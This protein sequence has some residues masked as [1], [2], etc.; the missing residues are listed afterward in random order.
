[1]AKRPDD[2]LRRVQLADPVADKVVR[3]AQLAVE[4]VSDRLVSLERQAIVRGGLMLDGPWP[5]HTAVRKVV[6]L[7]PGAVNK[8][9]HGL[10]RALRGWWI[11]DLVAVGTTTGAG[12]VERVKT[13]GAGG[14]PKDI[15][16][17]WLKPIGYTGA[18]ALEVT[19]WAF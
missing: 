16:D 18:T 1:M 19:I 15:A 9:K 10:A 7:T 8:L 13:D 12:H 6:T 3:G 4:K 2:G 17:L 11:T 5:D 14:V